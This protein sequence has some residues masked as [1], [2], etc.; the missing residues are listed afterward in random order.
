MC[1]EETKGPLLELLLLHICLSSSLSRG[2]EEKLVDTTTG[3]EM[4]ERGREEVEVFYM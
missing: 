1:Q 2:E 3:G 4:R